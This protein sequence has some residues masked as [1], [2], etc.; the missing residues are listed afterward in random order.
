M[1][2]CPIFNTVRWYK[3]PRTLLHLVTFAQISMCKEERKHEYNTCQ[4]C[5][6]SCSSEA[7]HSKTR[8]TCSDNLIQSLQSCCNPGIQEM[9]SEAE[10]RSV[11][12]TYFSL[13]NIVNKLQY[14]S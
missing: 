14:V 3:Q 9:A 4:L 5:F 8:Q 6:A 7:S 13:D 12:R 10:M 2:E 1:L 11:D